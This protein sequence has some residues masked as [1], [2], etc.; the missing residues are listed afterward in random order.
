MLDLYNHL[1]EA[2]ELASRPREWT[3]EDIGSVCKLIPDLLVM[4]RGLLV[5]HE[6]APSG[7]CRTCPVPW[8]CPVMTTIHRLVKDRVREFAAIAYRAGER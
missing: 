3:D 2:E 5:E 7:H 8:P 1:S 4:V 6:A